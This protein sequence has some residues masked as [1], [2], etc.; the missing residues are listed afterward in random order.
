MK[1]EKYL[2]VVLAASLVG[3]SSLTNPGAPKQSFNIEQDIVAL[4]QYYEAPRMGMRVTRFKS[5]SA[6]SSLFITV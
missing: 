1:A 4:E 2:A 5:V 6:N 3:C